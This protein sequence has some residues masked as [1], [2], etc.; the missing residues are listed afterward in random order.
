MVT[1]LVKDIIGAV[2][3]ALGVV[4]TLGAAAAGCVMLFEEGNDVELAFVPKE[5]KTEKK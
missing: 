5:D 1:K 3:M 2:F 4:F